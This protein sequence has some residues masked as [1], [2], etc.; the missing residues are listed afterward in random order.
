M[1][2]LRL[3]SDDEV[4]IDSFKGPPVSEEEA[5]YQERIHIIAGADIDMHVK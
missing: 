3:N 4:K 1:S 2:L 5:T